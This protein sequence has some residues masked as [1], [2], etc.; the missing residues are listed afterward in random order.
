M[1]G[2]AGVEFRRGEHPGC[3]LW[4]SFGRVARTWTL[5]LA[6]STL[7]LIA[8]D[9]SFEDAIR[10]GVDLHPDDLAGRKPRDRLLRQ[11]ESTKMGRGPGECHHCAG[12][13]ELALIGPMA[14]PQASGEG[15]P[16]VFLVDDGLL[17]VDLRIGVAQVGLVVVD[18]RLTDGLALSCLM[19]R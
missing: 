16:K 12:R 2:S 6:V 15:R 3:S 19:S 14:Q 7:G 1:L 10:E 18:D 13:Q 4:S 5:R 9:L 17:G 8:C 11:E